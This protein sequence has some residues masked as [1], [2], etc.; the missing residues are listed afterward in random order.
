MQFNVTT[1]V[2]LIDQ[3][4]DGFDFPVITLCPKNQF[5]TKESLGQLKRILESH[6][7]L[8]Q[9]S[10]TAS[11]TNQTLHELEKI[12]QIR[13]FLLYTSAYRLLKNVPMQERKNLTKSMG[14]MLVQCYF[15]RDI[16]CQP[17]DFEYIFN[18]WE[19]R[20]S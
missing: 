20:F 19:N 9:L 3:N 15:D 13:L 10:D 11:A 8:Q 7:E 17:T 16:Q 2:R 5:S 12:Q 6:Q 1:E 18:R 4:V 14:D